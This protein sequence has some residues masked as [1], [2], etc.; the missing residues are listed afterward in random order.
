MHVLLLYHFFH[1]DDVI[2]ARLFSDIAEELAR[3]EGAVVAMP[4]VRSCHDGKAAYAKSENWNGVEIRRVWRPDW[5]QSSNKGRIGNALFMLLGWTWRAVWTRRS[6]H[7]TVVIGTDPPLSVLVAIPWRVFRPRARIIHWCHDLYP[8]AAVAEGIFKADSW[9]VKILNALLR[10]AYARCDVIADLG[11]C[12]RDELLAASGQRLGENGERPSPPASLP[13]ELRVASSEWRGEIKKPSRVTLTPWALVEPVGVLEADEAVRRELFGDAKLGLLYSGNLGRAHVYEP[14]VEL[15]RRVAGDSIAFCYAGRGAGMA[16]L[17]DQLG[18]G[19]FESPSPPTPLPEA[20]RGEL[21]TEMGMASL[22][23]QLGD[24][25]FGSPSP[26]APLPSVLGRGEPGSETG[27]A[28]LRDEWRVA[29]G[30]R[31]V[32]AEEGEEAGLAARGSLVASRTCFAGFASEEELGKRL[33]AADV[34]MVSLAP[35]W[36]GTVVPSKFFGALAV[37]R[38]VLFAGS[39]RCAIARWIDE[40]DV[41]WVLDDEASVARVAEQLRAL[42]AEPEQ[43]QAMRER[44]FAVYHREF[45]KAV[46]LGKWKRLVV[47]G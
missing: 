13:K 44:C 36:T 11:L 25:K 23:D 27:Q 39:R 4:S 16:S 1:P 47:S 5:K 19:K 33:A 46:Q 2:S 8:Q 45:S 29:S 28:S 35:H 40:F 34:H 20:G 21:G 9:V 17:R 12:M 10:V 37:G 26:P 31:R 6:K 38:P 32:V 24:E 15:A 43:M 22:R 42:A 14:F 30:E 18:D 7:E 3:G 41:G